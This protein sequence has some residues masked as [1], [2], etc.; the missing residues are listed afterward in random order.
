[1]LPRKKKKKEKETSFLNSYNFDFGLI[2]YFWDGDERDGGF[3]FQDC[4]SAHV[5]Q[6][7]AARLLLGLLMF[8]HGSSCSHRLQ[9]NVVRGAGTCVHTRIYEGVFF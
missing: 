5:F 3:V 4:I 2:L 1:M 7:V 9:A 6:S 8:L